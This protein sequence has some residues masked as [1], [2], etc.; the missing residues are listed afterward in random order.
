MVIIGSLDV[1]G[2][3]MDIVRNFPPLADK[4][5][6]DVTLVLY[7]HK[8]TLY[9]QLKNT[10]IKVLS[11]VST[12]SPGASLFTK[13]REHFCR[14]RF[15]RTAI[16]NERPDIVHPFLP[17]AYFYTCLAHLLARG[18]RRFVLSRLSLNFYKTK[19]PL[20]AW[21]EQHICHRIGPH[22]FVGNARAVLEDL[23]TEGVPPHNMTLIYNGIETTEWTVSRP[24]S[25]YT[26]ATIFEITALGNLHPH[27]GYQDLIKA[28]SMLQK[29]QLPK[30]WHVNIAGRD[31]DGM[32]R[33]LQKDIETYGLEN[34]VS[35]LGHVADRKKLLQ[36][37]HL[38]VH[39]A[40]TEGLPNAIIEAMSA[41]LP[42]VATD[43]GGVSELIDG[44]HGLLVP[45]HLPAALA[46][47]LECL[48]R[49]PQR[50]HTLGQAGKVRA[51][52]QF[53]VQRSIE[54]YIKL[55][56][57]VMQTPCQDTSSMKS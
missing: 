30:P 21:V 45:S 31:V 17:G 43:V 33:I 38:F 24:L 48:L 44:A 47:A 46:Q 37:T 26:K 51:D 3:E 16:A 23:K 20:L 10:A 12:L 53:N 54:D 28:L 2:A 1:G 9:P 6:F 22:H 50:M 19:R 7:T 27:K 32:K 11:Q 4:D 36:K 8:G 55:Y 56:Q 49:A 40:H 52:G 18:K 34:H 25:F 41:S 15:V 35:L 13:I 29:V 42:V 5:E 14:F 57:S 39:P